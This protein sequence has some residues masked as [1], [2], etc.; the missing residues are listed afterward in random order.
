MQSSFAEML[1]SDAKSMSDTAFLC[2]AWHVP[3]HD[4]ILLV[5][6]M[7]LFASSALSEQMPEASLARWH[8]AT[9]TK[10]VGHELRCAVVQHMCLRRIRRLDWLG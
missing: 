4:K 1:S 8:H 10:Q 5:S 7:L 9:C 3:L 2:A 6:Y